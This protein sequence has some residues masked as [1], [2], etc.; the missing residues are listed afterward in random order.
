M[1]PFGEQRNDLRTAILICYLLN[2]LGH[3][4]K[5]IEPKHILPFLGDATTPEK[6]KLTGRERGIALERQ[7][8]FYAQLHNASAAGRRAG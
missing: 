6:P 1:E 8:A 5:A 7:F 4:K 3:A 2:G